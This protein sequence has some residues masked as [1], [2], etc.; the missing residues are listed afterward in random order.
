MDLRFVPLEKLKIPWFRN[1]CRSF[2]SKV[3]AKR[4]GVGMTEISCSHAPNF[5]PHV[6]N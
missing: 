1:F 6:V 2:L 5:R 4:R 3:A